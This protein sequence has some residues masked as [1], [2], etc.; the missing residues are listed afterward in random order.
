MTLNIIFAVSGLAIVLIITAKIVEEKFR[1]KPFLLRLISRG[2]ER[3]RILSQEMAHGYTDI[4]ERINFF[5]NKQFPLQ[6]RNF[7]NKT[8]SLIKSEAEKRI[9]DIRGSRFLKKSDGIS[10]Y[11]KSISEKETESIGSEPAETVTDS[12]KSPFEVK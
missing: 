7:I 2:D 8:N 4:K 9:G 3:A 1:R 6:A 12:Q 10:E 5:I 11:F